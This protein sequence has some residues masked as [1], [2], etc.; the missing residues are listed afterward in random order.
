VKD[1]PINSKIKIEDTVIVI[2]K[3]FKSDHSN[4]NKC[5]YCVFGKIERNSFTGSIHNYGCSLGGINT[6]CGIDNQ[7]EL[8]RRFRRN[9]ESNIREDGLN[10]V[11]KRIVK[12]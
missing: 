1:Y 4:E 2:V 9:F 6:K 8:N 12:R 11:Y 5:K 10:I 7:E 3:E